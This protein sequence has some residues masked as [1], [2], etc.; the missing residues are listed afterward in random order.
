MGISSE[1]HPKH[2]SNTNKQFKY[3]YTRKAQFVA[4][5]ERNEEGSE[6]I[7]L[8]DLELISIDSLIEKLS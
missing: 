4:L 2:S 5:V 8:K 3:A 6:V 1:L 7:T